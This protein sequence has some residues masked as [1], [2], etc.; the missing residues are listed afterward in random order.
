MQNVY[1]DQHIQTSLPN[2]RN[3]LLSDSYLLNKLNIPLDLHIQT[4][5]PNLKDVL[6]YDS[7]VMN[8]KDYTV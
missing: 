5:S 8:K 2:L 3:I 6:L 7:Y 1:V 4:P